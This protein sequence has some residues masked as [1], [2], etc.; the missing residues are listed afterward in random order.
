[1][2]GCGADLMLTPIDLDEGTGSDLRVLDVDCVVVGGNVEI[3]TDSHQSVVE[4]EDSEHVEGR[5]EEERN[6]NVPNR[7]D[8]HRNQV[9]TLEI[10]WSSTN[11]KT[12]EFVLE[13]L[14]FVGEL[15]EDDLTGVLVGEKEVKKGRVI[16]L[17]LFVGAGGRSD[18]FADEKLDVHDI[19]IKH[20]DAC[21]AVVS[22]AVVLNPLPV[23]PIHPA[24]P[25]RTEV[26]DERFRGES[27]VT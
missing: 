4:E 26:I 15:I 24:G 27:V 10:F 17:V 12:K 21:V 16:L 8:R 13:E 2:I 19:R 22:V 3:I 23:V 1:M 14:E 25:Q 5:D 7:R 11:G 6:D 20:V 18:V 9:V